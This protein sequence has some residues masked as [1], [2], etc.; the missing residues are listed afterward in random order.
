MQQLVE[1][2]GKYLLTVTSPLLKHPEK[3]QLRV[4]QAKEQKMVRFRL[5]V[6]PEDISLLIGRNGMTASAIRSL[7]KAAGEK[8]G[9]RVVVR[10]LSRDEIEEQ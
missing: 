1:T 4:A 10:M 3:A 7:A 6:E 5:V 8:Q 2:I 9:V